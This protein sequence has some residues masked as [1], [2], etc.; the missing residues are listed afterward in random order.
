VRGV[1][2]C[3]HGEAVAHGDAPDL[4]ARDQAFAQAV[5]TGIPIFGEG[6]T[7]LVE[8]LRASGFSHPRGTLVRH[9][10]QRHARG[11]MWAAFTPLRALEPGRLVISGTDL[12]YEG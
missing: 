2:V 9:I 1:C 6:L 7:R 4:A 10:F 11:L 3:S 5:N 12:G 8:G